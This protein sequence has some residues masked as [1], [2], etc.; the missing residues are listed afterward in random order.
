MRRVT[1]D[2]YDRPTSASWRHGAVRR[3]FGWRFTK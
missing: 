1:I 2:E 3:V